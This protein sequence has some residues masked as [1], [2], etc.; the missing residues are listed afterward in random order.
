EPKIQGSQSPRS[1]GRDQHGRNWHQPD[2]YARPSPGGGHLSPCERRHVAV[3]DEDPDQG[4]Q[5]WCPT[6][7]AYSE[8]HTERLGRAAAM[9]TPTFCP[10]LTHH[11]SPTLPM[12]VEQTSRS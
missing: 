12:V 2:C 8:L 7:S 11:A 4:E 6:P 1:P 5:A 9:H 3:G 10:E